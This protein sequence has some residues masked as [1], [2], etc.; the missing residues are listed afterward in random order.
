MRCRLPQTTTTTKPP[1]DRVMQLLGSHLKSIYVDA[2]DNT[3]IVSLQGLSEIREYSMTAAGVNP[4]TERLP[5]M[6]AKSYEENNFLFVHDASRA[7]NAN[8][9]S[10][11]IDNTRLEF[12]F[13]F[14]V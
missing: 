3:P 6:D 5:L 9:V 14:K 10:A 11:P 4:Y 8:L 7:R 2:G 12:L 1:I 13:T